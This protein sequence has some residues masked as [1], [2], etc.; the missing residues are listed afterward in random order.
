VSVGRTTARAALW[1]FAATA[2]AKAVT[3]VGLALL[4]RLLAP[5]EFGLLAFAL[6][7]ITYA[8]TIGDLGSGMALV[9]WPDRREDAA[10]VTFLINV[11]AGVLW[12]L[13]TIAIAPWVADFFNAPNGTA[14]VQVLAASFIIKYLGNTHDALAQKDLRFKARLVPEMAL[15]L[16]KAAVSLVLAW[17]GFGAWSLV[18]GHL[19][20]L[21]CRTA[22]LWVVVPWRPAWRFPRDLFGPMLGYGRGIIAVNILAAITHHA[23]LAVVGRFLGMS[24]LGVYQMASKIPETTVVVLLWVVSRVLFP[25]FSRLHAAGESL[26]RPY[27][28]ATRYVTA[29]TLPAAVGLFVL[30][31]PIVLT[32]FG[33][34]WIGAAPILAALSVHAASRCVSTH[35]GDALKATGRA[36]LLARLAVV[37]ALVIVPAVIAGATR[38]AVT[39]AI[40]LSGAEVVTATFTLLIASRIIGVTMRAIGRAI[41]PGATAAAVMIIPLLFW[42][43]L[44]GALPPVV[45]MLGGVTIGAIAY[46]GVLALIDR[47]IFRRARDHFFPRPGVESTS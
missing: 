8:E 30:A 17:Q 35:A 42:M 24:A 29:M 7:Y 5:A 25:A 16:F 39:V 12:C 36:G 9:Y 28:L 21:T 23:D 3:L 14:I 33:P 6:V 20:G 19:A 18:W 10:Q 34:A 4:A 37:K 31:R 38:D 11:A 13:L 47:E 43:R 32:F 44:S 40:A 22:L 46:T 41:L 1:A 26:R 45:Q 2:G 27:L 15:A